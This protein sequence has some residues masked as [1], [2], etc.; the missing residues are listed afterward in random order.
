MMRN[1]TYLFFKKS[2]VWLSVFLFFIASCQTKKSIESLLDITLN[3]NIAASK[4]TSSF[5]CSVYEVKDKVS[6]RIQ[7]TTQSAFTRSNDVL[8][9]DYVVPETVFKI[10]ETYYPLKIPLYLLFKNIKIAL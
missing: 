1:G 2:I 4:T 9:T 8:S 10:S 7:K 5:H 6:S 3:K